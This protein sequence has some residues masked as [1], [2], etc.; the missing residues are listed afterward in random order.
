M[1]ELPEKRTDFTHNPGDVVV[2][3]GNYY[4]VD[5]INPKH[6]FLSVSRNKKKNGQKMASFRSEW[7]QLS[8]HEATLL[9][10]HIKMLQELLEKVAANNV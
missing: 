10:E 5:S 8:P 2:N 4:V 9:T 1:I 6:G 7:T 3:K